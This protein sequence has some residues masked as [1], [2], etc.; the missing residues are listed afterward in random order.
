M[1]PPDHPIDK[2]YRTHHSWLSGWLKKRLNCSEEAADIAQDTF[3]KLLLKP[4]T[5]A[6][7]GHA[8]ALLVTIAKGLC[9][10]Q[11]RRKRIE[12]EWRLAM[13]Q[14][15]AQEDELGQDEQAILDTLIVLDQCLSQ[16]PKAVVRA[17]IGAHLQGFTY[18][19]LAEQL[20]V[21]ERTIKRY[22]AQALVQCCQVLDET[23]HHEHF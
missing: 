22:V 1:H 19:E 2:V 15:L 20:N 16:L 18:L 10:D 4:R 11:W 12:Q 7:L 14:T 17:F 8:R 3:V 13:Q 5:F 9:V 23:E 6:D 21:S